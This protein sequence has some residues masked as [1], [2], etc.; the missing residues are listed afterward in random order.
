[1]IGSVELIC[2]SSPLTRGKPPPGSPRPHLPGLIPAHAG[3]TR[4]P[5]SVR[6]LIRAHPRSR[7]ENFVAD[8]AALKG[9]GSSPLTRGK[10]LCN[11]RACKRGGLIP[12]HAGKTA[13][14][15]LHNR[16]SG[17]HPRSRGENDVKTGSGLPVLGSS[18]LTRGKHDREIE[19]QRQPGLI[20]AHAGKTLLF[21]FPRHGR[22]LIPAHAGKT[23]RRTRSPPHTEA[24]PRSRGE[25][26][27]ASCVT[28]APAGSSPLTRGKRLSGHGTGPRHRLIPAHAGKTTAR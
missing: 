9:W 21:V 7:G 24:H 14:D 18:P 4:E 20:P 19:Q 10:R 25:N 26:P 11:T 5:Q 13:W 28:F 22:R 23:G 12:A 16:V 8:Y 1:M 27:G 3:K 2:G 6:K 17:A 15:L